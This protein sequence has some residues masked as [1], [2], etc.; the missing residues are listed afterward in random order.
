[1]EQVPENGEKLTE[2]NAV[3]SIS[4]KMG[5]IFTAIAVSE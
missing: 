5:V 3:M 4:G 1:M 2:K